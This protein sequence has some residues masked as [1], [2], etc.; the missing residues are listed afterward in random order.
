MA[1]NIYRLKQFFLTFKF[2]LYTVSQE[3]DLQSTRERL[4][5]SKLNKH[6]LQ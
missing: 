2:S 1:A 6:E 3:E 4:D 5:I